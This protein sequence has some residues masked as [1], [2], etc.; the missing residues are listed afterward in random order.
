M[1]TLVIF[2]SLFI[3]AS[4]DAQKGNL[5]LSNW[6][7]T[8][9]KEFSVRPEDYS[10]LKKGKL[11]YSLSNDNDNIYIS[12]KIE[13]PGVQNRILKEGLIV[14]INMDGKSS[15]KMG[16]RYP[17]GSQSSEGRRR[18]G[19]PEA[20]TNADGS[21]VTPL[22]LANTIELIGFTNE[23]ARRFPADNADNFKGSLRFNN[24]GTL[25]YWMAMPIAKLPVRN[26]KDSSGAMPFTLGIEY[27]AV[28][29]NSN[30]QGGNVAQPPP[31]GPPSGGS[32]GGPSGGGRAGGGQSG[33]RGQ[34]MGTAQTGYPSSQNSTP[35]VLLWLKNIRL[36]TDR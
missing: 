17:I 16:I 10:F 11:W 7:Q 24:E 20:K 18:P 25:F 6:H 29:V 9:N 22:S 28:Q 35:S 21:L 15:K 3:S 12:L 19:M 34:G 5:I 33:G 32:R 23:V 4:I 2:F 30:G 27:G 26:S 31:S 36:A 13:D 8:E 1:K 14:W